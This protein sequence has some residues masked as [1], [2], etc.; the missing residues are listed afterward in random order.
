MSE[1][2]EEKYIKN[3]VCYTLFYHEYNEVKFV[4]VHVRGK[5]SMKQVMAKG[6]CMKFSDLIRQLD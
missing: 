3:S 4:Y 5:M 2:R 6:F 1:H